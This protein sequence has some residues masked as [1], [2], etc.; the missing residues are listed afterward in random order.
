MWS[1]IVCHCPPSQSWLL[2]KSSSL[3]AQNLLVDNCWRNVSSQRIKEGVNSFF[4]HGLTHQSLLCSPPT[5]T[6]W[7]FWT[8]FNPAELASNTRNEPCLSLQFLLLWR[9]VAVLL[10]MEKALSGWKHHSNGI[11]RTPRERGI[12]FSELLNW[13]LC[14]LQMACMLCSYWTKRTKQ[15]LYSCVCYALQFYSA[16]DNVQGCLNNR[17]ILQFSYKKQK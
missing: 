1:L 17:K 13:G 3:Y 8:N 5:S 9:R 12:N 2:S 14:S 6:S 16:F 4:S 10:F 7:P 11:V 15:L